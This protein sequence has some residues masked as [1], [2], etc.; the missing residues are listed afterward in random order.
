MRGGTEDQRT[1]G[2]KADTMLREFYNIPFALSLALLCDIYEVYSHIANV[3]QIRNI[4]FQI[5]M[6]K[7]N[8]KFQ[9]SLVCFLMTDLTRSIHL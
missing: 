1:K 5:N 8:I 6:L 9:R 2:L 7:Q 4:L 3:L